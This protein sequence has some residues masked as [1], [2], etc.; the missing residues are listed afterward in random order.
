MS[1]C[2]LKSPILTKN[3]WPHTILLIKARISSI[4]A[5]G[6][7]FMIVRVL[8][9]LG[10]GGKSRR[11]MAS[12]LQINRL[13]GL[14]PVKMN[15]LLPVLTNHLS[16]QSATPTNKLWQWRTQA[17][18]SRFKSETPLMRRLGIH[19]N[20]P[21]SDTKLMLD[22]RVGLI[23]S[24]LTAYKLAPVNPRA[25]A[26]PPKMS[27]LLETKIMSAWSSHQGLSL[28]AHS[29]NLGW[30]AMSNQQQQMFIHDQHDF[31]QT[32]CYARADPVLHHKLYSNWLDV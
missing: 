24:H 25:I 18:H 6:C 30:N 32:K 12:E 20:I 23:S 17:E 19:K 9:Y 14:L 27:L 31:Q 10:K 1:Q 3:M 4:W 22:P 29:D 2:P 5:K 15:G 28:F 16:H 13:P 21:V 7:I 11:R 8:S 26:G